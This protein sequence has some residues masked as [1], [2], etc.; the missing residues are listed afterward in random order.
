MPFIFSY[1]LNHGTFLVLYTKILSTYSLYI[2]CRRT[3]TTCSLQSKNVCSSKCEAFVV[4]P[5]SRKVNSPAGKN[6]AL[7]IADAIQRDFES[8]VNTR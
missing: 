7:Q 5:L 3:H 8:N 6:A 2:S 4:Q 1:M